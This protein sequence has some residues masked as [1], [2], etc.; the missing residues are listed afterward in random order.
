MAV[1]VRIRI[2]RKAKPAGI[3]TAAVL[4]SGYE[5][6]E[7]QVLV[8]ARVAEL[9]QLY[10]PPRMRVQ[11]Q[12]Y[13]AVGRSIRLAVIPRAVTVRVLV[14]GPARRSVTCS[15]AIS[16]HENEVLLND[17]AIGSLGVVIV[18]A[19]AG[20]WRFRN[21]RAARGTECPQYW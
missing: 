17:C 20:T 8:P 6:K 9:L 7:P 5:S 2:E 3:E 15:A 14:R 4:N 13:E 21:E 19:R 11:T 10:P 1:R 18:D 16:E 12:T